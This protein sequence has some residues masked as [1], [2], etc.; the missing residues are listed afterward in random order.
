MSIINFNR[1][2]V[3]PDLAG[4]R[5]RAWAVVLQYG[6][7]DFYS[8][9][10][11]NV[12]CTASHT[13]EAAM[14]EENKLTVRIPKGDHVAARVKCL[15]DGVQLSEVVRRLLALWV[16]GQVMLEEPPPAAGPPAENA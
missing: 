4:A 1:L 13:N 6:P 14:R 5:W 15:R 10:L 8:N 3:A 9:W 12:P 7:L 16:A 11:Y 2:A